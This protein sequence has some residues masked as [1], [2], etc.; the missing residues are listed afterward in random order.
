MRRIQA[1][2]CLVAGAVV[3]C[4]TA[5]AGGGGT[6]ASGASGKYADKVRQIDSIINVPLATG[7]LVGASVAVVKGNDTI[8]LK[9]YGKANL[10]F[11]VP[12][13]PHAVYEIGSVTKQFTGAAMMQL[14][15]QG[16]VSLDDDMHK[17][18]PNF[19]TQGRKITVRQ[20]LNHT[21]GIKG[22]T[23]IPE[24]RSLTPLKAPRD[25]LLQIVSK[26]PHDFEPGEEEIYNNTGFFLAGLI[27]EKVSGMPYEEYVQK[28][29]FDRAGMKDS[30]YCSETK[31]HKGKVTGYD[32]DSTGPI[33]KGPLSHQ[34]P[35]AA[36]SL[37]SSAADLVAWNTALHRDGKIL[38]PE[39]YKEF[40][41]ADTLNDGS[42]LGYGKG[43][44]VYDRLGHHALHHGGGINGFL[45][46]NIYFPDDS[47]SVV[48]LYN[49]AGPASPDAAA[50]AIAETVIGETKPVAREIE[51][52]PARYAGVYTGRGRGRP[53]EFTVA[54]DHGKVTIK[55]QREDSAR[56]LTYIGNNTFL[57]DEA[58]ITFIENGGKVTKLRIDA[59]YGN[60]VLTKK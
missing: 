30:H 46:E 54:V 3:A 22:Y 8:A 27:I 40:I 21:S 17:Y 10:E 5:K 58:K 12:T 4:G 19:D 53:A 26:K 32:S 39:A 9:A 51:S 11:D 45:S 59:G 43:I 44:A 41:H 15:E 18:L 34:W 31:I 23:E 13:P 48:V 25:T 55:G 7:K 33:I 47:L 6:A 36:G 42:R 50:T 49:T 29:L 37:C 60:N 56:A 24:F 2:W 20:L 14:V 28:N 52:D 16:K 57:R 35:Y 1:G 38:G